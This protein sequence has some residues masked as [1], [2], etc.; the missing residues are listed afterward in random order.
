MMSRLLTL[1]DPFAAMHESAHKC[2]MRALQGTYNGWHPPATATS[3]P[4]GGGQLERPTRW[5]AVTGRRQ[6]EKGCKRTKRRRGFGS[7]AMRAEARASDVRQ[8]PVAR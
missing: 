4:D 7:T 8:Q 1:T 5:I 2:T 3:R 6:N